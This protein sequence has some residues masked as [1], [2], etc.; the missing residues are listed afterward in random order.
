MWGN[1]N[2]G[3]MNNELAQVRSGLYGG[4]AHYES[5]ATTGFGEKKLALDVF[6]A[7]PG[8]IPSRQEF[9]GTG[10]SFYYLR[11]QDILMGSE[12]VRIE[13]RDKASGIVTGVVN[14]QPSVDYD[15]DY[16]QGN[17][18]LSEPLA[19]TANDDLLVRSGSVSG[20]EA[21][22]VVR[23][24]YTP[25]FDEVD[26]M[27]IGGQAHYW[28]NDRLKVGLMANDNNNDDLRLSEQSCRQQTSQS[29]SAVPPG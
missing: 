9:R 19:S 17:I 18:L 29:G 3:Y 13:I 21:Y 12:R 6:G 11:H 15:V 20:D 5:D 2:V 26:A 25:G 28:I 22:L 4:Q 23:Y 10:G 16:L 24:E 8:T 1:F 7:Q 14:L 27:A